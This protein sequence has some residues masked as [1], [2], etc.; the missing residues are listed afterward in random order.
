MLIEP[1]LNTIGLSNV[2]MA[3]SQIL[4][5]VDAR[6]NCVFEKNH[7]KFLSGRSFAT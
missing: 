1:A 3:I 4:N 7:A 2:E 6:T 5:D